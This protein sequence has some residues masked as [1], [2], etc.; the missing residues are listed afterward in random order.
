[1][2]KKEKVVAKSYEMIRKPVITEKS[3][4]GS[5]Y[6][7]VTFRV[8]MDADKKEIKAAV[9]NLYKVT[10]LSV[11]TIV[12]KGKTKSF[13]GSEGVRSDYKKA[14]VKLAE[15]SNIDVTVGVK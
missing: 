7:Q 3:M 15:G 5:E 6:G 12:V 9:E 13:R 2:S 11:N 8:P 10:V 4:K 1:M 14:V